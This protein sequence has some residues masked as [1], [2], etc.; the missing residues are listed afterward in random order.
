GYRG[1]FAGLEDVEI[2]F[3]SA[4]EIAQQL[5]SGRAHLGV[6]GED[7][8][9]ESIADTDEKVDFLRPLGFGG[10][11]VVVAVPECWIDVQRMS[12]LEDVGAL[13]Y[14]EHGR[15]LRVA[16]KYPNLTRRH[17]A[18]AGVAGYRIVESLG[19]TEGTPAAG[20]A[21][22]IVDITTTGTTLKANHLKVLDDGV[23]LR[24]QAMLVASKAAMW[25]GTAAKIRDE[26]LSRLDAAGSKPAPAAPSRKGKRKSG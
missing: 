10:A 23:I 17:F 22:I 6:T 14:R 5:R 24:S 18:A 21:E 15:R 4:S 16:T 8:V 25:N 12:D 7:L 11:D 19:A 20:T 2:A 13:F 1:E 3:L 9:R 26:L